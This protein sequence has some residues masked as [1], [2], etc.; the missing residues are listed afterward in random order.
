MALLPA[1]SAW[2]GLACLLALVPIAAPQAEVLAY[3]T[4]YVKLP[5]GETRWRYDASEPTREGK[6]LS[7]ELQFVDLSKTDLRGAQ[8]K[9]AWLDFADLRDAKLQ[10]AVFNSVQLPHADL[11]GAVLRGAKFVP[12]VH[13]GNADL[14]RVDLREAEIPTRYPKP[15]WMAVSTFADARFDGADLRG[16]DFT[17]A[18]IFGAVFDGADLRGANLA[19]TMS[20]PKS[21]RGARYDRHTRFP[22]GIDPRAW[23]MIYVPDG[24]GGDVCYAAC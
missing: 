23:G 8:I 17:R 11:R 13:F 19:N 12:P 24:D 9:D 2:A 3:A 5:P 1:R 10:D 18:L 21:M 20:L 14:R 6:S 4:D 16:V 15:D 7:G 22:E